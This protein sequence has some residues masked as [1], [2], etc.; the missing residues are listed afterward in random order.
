MISELAGTGEELLVYCDPVDDV[1]G[2]RLW[3]DDPEVQDIDQWRGQNLLGFTLMELRSVYREEMPEAGIHNKTAETW[4]ASPYA[5]DAPYI[6]LNYFCI[7]GGMTR[8]MIY[9][10][11]HVSVYHCVQRC[12]DPRLILIS[13]FGFTAPSDRGRCPFILDRSNRRIIRKGRIDHG[14]QIRQVFLQ[15][16][17]FPRETDWIRSSSGHAA[18]SP[19]FQGYPAAFRYVRSS[20]LPRLSLHLPEIRW[21][22]WQ[23]S[24][25]RQVWRPEVRG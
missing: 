8:Q 5:G 9:H 1:L 4:G 7:D 23:Q 16:F 12:P 20:R 10:D 17:P 24:G 25:R 15:P 2:I 18:A 19:S 21:Q 13:Q 6:Y 3:K 11:E 14:D 22:S